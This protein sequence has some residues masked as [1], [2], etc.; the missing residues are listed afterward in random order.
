MTARKEQPYQVFSLPDLK[1]GDPEIKSYHDHQLD[2]LQV[3]IPGS[4]PW[5]CLPTGL[6][7]FSFG[8]LI[9]CFINWPE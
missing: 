8:F 6:P 4:T 2:L 5:L 7:P 3:V 1:S 9:I